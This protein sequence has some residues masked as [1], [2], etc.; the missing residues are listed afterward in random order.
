MVVLCL[1]IHLGV[2]Y[3]PI[4]SYKEDLRPADNTHYFGIS[5][6]ATELEDLP[7]KDK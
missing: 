1:E 4:E 6:W 2:F 5:S 3:K 7:I